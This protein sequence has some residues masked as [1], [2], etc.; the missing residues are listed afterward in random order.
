MS[1]RSWAAAAA[2]GPAPASPAVT[3]RA[4]APISGDDPAAR[5]ARDAVPDLEML[6]SA[7]VPRLRRYFARCGAG[8]EAGDL[9]QESFARLAAT[10]SSGRPALERPAAYLH[11]VATNLLRSRARTALRRSLAT[12]VPADTVPLAGPDPVRA[13]EARDQ[14]VRLQAALRRLSPKTRDIFL[15]HRI[16]GQTYQEIATQAGLSVK[17]VEWHMTK[18]IGFIDRALDR[19]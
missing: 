9:V 19:R 7:E 5:D 8:Q 1:Q 18:A 2:R 11:R 10:G 6:Y 12:H 16:D 17:T 15:A 13:L 4:F 14:L 3:S